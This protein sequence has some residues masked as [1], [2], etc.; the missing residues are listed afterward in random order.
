MKKKLTKGLYF[1]LFNL[2]ND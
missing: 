2:Y 1:N